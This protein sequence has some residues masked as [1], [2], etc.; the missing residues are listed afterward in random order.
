MVPQLRTHSR[1]PFLRASNIH[2]E[3]NDP[4]WLANSIAMECIRMTLAPQD[5]MLHRGYTLE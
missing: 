3:N 1:K 4:E 2:I 5:S